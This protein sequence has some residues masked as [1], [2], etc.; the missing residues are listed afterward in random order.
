MG[1]D[2]RVA[3]GTVVTPA[4]RVA[5]DV[6]VDAGKIVGVVSSSFAADAERTVDA[7]GKFVLPG[8]VDV[9]VHTREPGFEH[10]EDIETTT[11]QAAVGGVT[12]I[13]GMPNLNPPTTDVETLTDVFTR[14][15]RTSLVDYN[16]NPAPTKY[17]EIQ[18]MSDMGVQAYKIYM[19]VDTG[20]TYPHPAGTGMHDHGELLRMMDLIAKTGKRF[21][22]HPHDQALMDYIEGEYL[23][24][25]DNTPEAYAS[26]YAARSGVIW[27]TAIDVCLRLAEASGCPI[28]IAHMQTK[29]SVE[30]VRRAKAAGI[31][32]TCE[33]NHWMPFLSTWED[34]KRLGPYAL[35]YWVPDEGRDAVWE[36]MV[37]GTIDICSSDHAPHTRAEKEVGWTKMWSCHTGTPGIQYYY[38]LLLDAVNQE[39]L[40]VEQVVSLVATRPA[41]AFGL[42]GIKGAIQVGCDADL[43]VANMN[44][45]W[46]ILDD[47]VLSRCGWTPYHEREISVNIEKTFVRGTE[48]FGDGQVLG[49]PGH[50]RLAS[51]TA[52]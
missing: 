8:M 6:L 46:T 2:L 29:R 42:W 33:V 10:K 47:G 27:D 40:T 3:G 7:S 50:G 14:Y 34:V 37:D 41:Q 17:G 5:A 21:I 9:H 22:I 4:G 1:I 19:V 36:G 44:S 31:D 28:H 30:A 26:A 52:V 16:H 45:P 11:R 23:S 35:S 13:F 15:S 12:T 18:A 25:G 39:K 43:V 38:P 24:R 48:V 32:V 20:R 51:A 49:T